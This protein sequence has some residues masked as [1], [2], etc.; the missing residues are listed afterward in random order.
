MRAIAKAVQCGSM[1]NAAR[2]AQPM[3]LRPS[4]QIVLVMTSVTATPRQNAYETATASAP[5][6][7][8]VSTIVMMTALALCVI[9]ASTLLNS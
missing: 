8:P 7:F 9:T 3:F 4:I 6:I 5:V 1:E 2:N